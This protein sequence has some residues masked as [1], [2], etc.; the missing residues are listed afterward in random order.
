MSTPHPYSTL[1]RYELLRVLGRGAMG[2]V[3]EARDPNLERRVAIKTIRV[4]NLSQDAA[5]EYAARFRTEARSV[6]RLQHPNIVSVYDSD[7]DGDVAYLVMEF[8]QGEDLKHHLDAG[9]RFTLEQA[10]GVADDLLAALDYAHQQN[11]VHRDVKPANLLIEASGRAK[12]ADF[13]VARI[14]DA[15]EATRTRGSMVGTLKY[16]SPEQVQGQ[17]V[18]ARSDIF[19]AGVLLYQL[20]TGQRPFD[21]DTD[22]AVIQQIVAQPSAAASSLNP[23]LPSALDAVLERS[24]AKAR[25][26]RYA[27]AHDFAVALREATAGIV[28]R[29]VLPPPGGRQG[30]FGTGSSAGS[31]P[32]AGST[33]P[34]GP[35]PG[36]DTGVTM[37]QE[38][39]LVYWKDVRD[40][41]EA[42]DLEGFLARFP[43]GI[44]ADLARR[45]LRKLSGLGTSTRGSGMFDAT[46]MDGRPAARS[47]ESGAGTQ[48]TRA[49]GA[50][51]PAPQPPAAS[52]DATAMPKSA[53]AAAPTV[54]SDSTVMRPATGGGAAPVPPPSVEPRS[55][56]RSKRTAMVVAGVVIL[57]GAV[58]AFQKMRSDTPQAAA[59]ASLATPL[60]NPASAASGPDGMVSAAASAALAASTPSSAGTTGTLRIVQRPFSPTPLVATAAPETPAS[61]AG[62]QTGASA[63]ASTAASLAPA[64]SAMRPNPPSTRPTPATAA[65]AGPAPSVAGGPAQACSGRVL[66]GYQICL[67]EQCAMPAFSSHPLCVERRAAEKAR[68]DVFSN[69]RN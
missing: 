49:A 58:L 15:G 32:R 24:M 2:L 55:P 17:P 66:M 68:R 41:A 42:A 60:A 56:A 19:A 30:G 3:Y 52:E 57:A 62:S 34:F 27:T 33:V 37:T 8:V 59:Q 29:G 12:L 64:S 50:S 47:D 44:Y 9:T 10:L 36:D 67:N 38:L 35:R 20:L 45:R 61:A 18:D 43:Q 6:A 13:G 5:A 21:A 28:D 23:M 26:A 39:E 7:R 53:A 63:A 69:G 11:I 65:S 4:D 46:L 51:W 31:M 25:D 54:S 16:M 48:A 14:Q 22:F 40:S 1:G